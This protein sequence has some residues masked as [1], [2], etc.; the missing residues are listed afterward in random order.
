MKHFRC[1][2]LYCEDELP[3]SGRPNR[4][5]NI[6]LMSFNSLSSVCASF[7][8]LV[9]WFNLF[10]LAIALLHFSWHYVFILPWLLV[11]LWNQEIEPTGAIKVLYRIGLDLIA[12]Y[13]IPFYRFVPYIVSRLI[14]M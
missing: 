3:N 12:M 13:R 8:H 4:V 9:E 2:I 7:S 5:L 10:G 14:I 6:Q 1:F 11:L